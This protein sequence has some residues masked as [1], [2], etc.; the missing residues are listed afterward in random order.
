MARTKKTTAAPGTVIGYLRVSTA[1]QGDSG[2]GL[3]AQLTAIK[4]ECDR[5]GLVLVATHSDVISGKTTGRPGLDAAL[6]AVRTGAASGL[7]VAKLDRLSRSLAHFVALFEAAKAQRWALIA[8]DL[9]IDM[10]T[11]SGELVANVMASIAQW[12]RRTISDRTKAALAAKA[13]TGHKLGRPNVLDTDTA[14]NIVNLHRSGAGWSA[15]ARQLNE[16]GI[17]T[18]HGGARW[19]PSTVRAVVLGAAS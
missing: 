5:K 17:P 15:I 1:E 2:L 18:A 8:V 12:E 16:A 7:I 4:A 14:A 9:G 3:D 11:A 10:T 13:A 6:T 19:Y